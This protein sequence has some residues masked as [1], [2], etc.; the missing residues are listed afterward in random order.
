M[1]ING[2]WEDH[3][4]LAIL[5]EAD[6][7]QPSSIQ[8]YNPPVIAPPIGPYTHITK[9]PRESELLVFSGQVGTD[10]EESA[11]RYE[12]AGGEHLGNIEKLLA[13]D[14]MSADH[15][16]K[17]NIWAAQEVDWDHFHQVWEKFHGEGAGHDDGLRAGIGDA[18]HSGGD[19]GMGS[20]GIALMNRK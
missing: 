14:A 11:G 5:N 3:Q 10:S 7:Q 1:K 4:T 8:R 16:V 2:T 13:A 15:I 19:R 18:V 17:I 6:E 12:G 9:V 20:E